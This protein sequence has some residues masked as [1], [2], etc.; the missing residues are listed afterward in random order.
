MVWC[1]LGACC[2]LLLFL[3]IFGLFF[4]LVGVI[5]LI[6]GLG[7]RFVFLLVCF[8]RVWGMVR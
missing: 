7:G 1:S 2:L 5:L 6:C 3:V 8:C 4:G